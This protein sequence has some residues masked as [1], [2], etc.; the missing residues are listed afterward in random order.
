MTKRIAKLELSRETVRRLGDGT[1]A[2]EAW[3]APYCGTDAYSYCT[4]CAESV[5]VC[6]V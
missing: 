3:T 4:P 1:R 2:A 5:A 6:G